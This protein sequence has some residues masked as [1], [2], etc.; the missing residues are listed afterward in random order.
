MLGPRNVKNPPQKKVT[1]KPPVA[2]RFPCGVSSL[3]PWRQKQ[4]ALRGNAPALWLFEPFEPEV[5]S[6]WNQNPKRS[7][8][9]ISC[10]CFVLFLFS[11]ITTSIP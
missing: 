11:M 5:H 9:L 1:L 6:P 10:F 8:L 7:G 2:H 3:S 4:M